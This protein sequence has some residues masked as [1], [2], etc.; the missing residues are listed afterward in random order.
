MYAVPLAAAAKRPPFAGAGPP[1][2]FL[3]CLGRQ[4]TRASQ[5]RSKQLSEEKRRKEAFTKLERVWQSGKE[6]Y[7]RNNMNPEKKKKHEVRGL[8][9]CVVVANVAGVVGAAAAA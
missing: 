3:V 5:K 6:V 1:S 4:K 2:P 7:R 9:G 8:R